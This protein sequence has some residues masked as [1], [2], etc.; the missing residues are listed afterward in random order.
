[1]PHAALVR[2]MACPGTAARALAPLSRRLCAS[3]A[4]GEPVYDVLVV[5]GGV[6]GSLLAALLRCAPRAALQ[7]CSPDSAP[8]RSAEP[9]TAALRVAV[10]DPSPLSAEPPA[11]G[12]PSAR[13]STLTPASVRALDAAGA[14]RAVAAA[15]ATGWFDAMQ[16]W[17]ASGGGHVRYAAAEAARVE[18]GHVAEN[19]VLC[20]ALAAALRQDGGV[21][22]HARDTLQ[23]LHLP[24]RQPAGAAEAEAEAPQ[25]AGADWARARLAQAGWLHARLVVAADGPRSPTRALAGA[26]PTSTCALQSR[27]QV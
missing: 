5:G 12:A 22:L 1:M 13:C 4:A 25:A 24:R 3:A 7:P 8:A 19:G 18:L 21:A 14:W 9:L 10:V 20:A 6:V 17:D 27:Q 2:P 23:E 15:P 16:V 11:H 26:C